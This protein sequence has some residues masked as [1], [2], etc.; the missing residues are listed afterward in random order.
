MP[1][2]RPAFRQK[3]AISGESVKVAHGDQVP[4]RGVAMNV[5]IG[6]LIEP[7]N[8][9]CALGN[10]MWN[11]VVASLEFLNEAKRLAHTLYIS[12]LEE[13]AL[14]DVGFIEEPGIHRT[15]ARTRQ[16]SL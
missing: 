12:N 15:R 8:G 7:I 4:K 3:S 2:R 6:I 11:L 10:L 13:S 1:T 16:E 9:T 14:R 5:D